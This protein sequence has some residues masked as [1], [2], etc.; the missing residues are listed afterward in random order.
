ML[1]IPTVTVITVN[2]D[3]ALEHGE[4]TTGSQTVPAENGAVERLF[5]GWCAAIMASH[6]NVSFRRTQTGKNVDVA[7]FADEDEGL[8]FVASI[9]F[10]NVPFH[11]AI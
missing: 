2:P 3:I 8:R 6:P 1:T 11:V 5:G 10:L 7:A 9:L 4:A